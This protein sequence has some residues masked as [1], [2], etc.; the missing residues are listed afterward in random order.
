MAGQAFFQKI[1]QDIIASYWAIPATMVAVVFL[2][3]PTTVWIDANFA[4]ITDLLPDALLTTQVDGAR[5]LLSTIAQSSIGVAGVMYSMTLVAV[6]FASGNFGP[7]L[8]GNFMRD[9]G[10]QLSLGWM[11]SSFVYA[12]LVLRTVRDEGEPDG[13]LPDAFVPHL[14]LLVAILFALGSV[15]VMIYFIH[16]IPETISLSRIIATLG[17]R[18]DTAVRHLKGGSGSNPALVQLD[19]T[20]WRPDAKI[21]DATE[22]HFEDPGYIQTVNLVHMRR[23]AEQND[24]HLEIRAMPGTFVDQETLIALIWPQAAPVT[25]KQHGQVRACFAVGLGRTENQNLLFLAEQLVEIIARALSPGINDPFTANTCLSWLHVAL[26]SA[27]RSEQT[28]YRDPRDRVQAPIVSF[29][30]LLHTAHGTSRTYLA[31]D[32]NVALHAL[33]LLTRLAELTPP[34]PR[35]DAILTEHRL[36]TQEA[37]DQNPASTQI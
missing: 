14:S 19:N 35:Q 29:L 30:S 8:I 3:A 24:W 36:L 6:S 1:I 15:W 13:I 7:R 9:R 37:K 31:S 27:I 32:P 17:R 4:A 20:G 22:V 16:H 10:T 2:L 34:G 25:D 28:A 21:E 26:A 5:T 12:L 23:L 18:L 11:L 33:A